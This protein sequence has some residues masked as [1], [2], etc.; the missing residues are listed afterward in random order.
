MPIREQQTTNKQHAIP[1]SIMSVEFKIIGDLTLKQFFY[2]LAFGGGAYACFMTIQPFVFKWILVLFLTGAGLCFAFLPLGDR[3]LDVW[4]VNFIKAMLAPNQYVYR[5]QEE[6]PNVFL[7]QNLDVLRSELITLSPT[8]SRRK[9]EAYLEQQS[10]PIDKLDI[11]ERS[12]VLMVKSAYGSD[13]GYGSAPTTTVITTEE[14]LEAQPAPPAEVVETPAAQPVAQPVA[15]ADLTKLELPSGKPAPQIQQPSLATPEPAPQVERIVKSQRH[16][17]KEKTEPQDNYYSPTITPDMHAGRRFINLTPN[18]GGGGEIILPI[19]GERVLKSADTQRLENDEA[20]KAKQLDLLINQIK[21]S[22]SAQER[23]AEAQKFSEQEKSQIEQLRQQTEAEK[24]AAR[25]KE[26]QEEEIKQA[27]VAV[28]TVNNRPQINSEQENTQAYIKIQQQSIPLKPAQEESP[29][30][31]N[32]I[33]GIVT[34]AQHEPRMPIPGVVAV[35]RNQRNEVVR[36]V[37]T[38]AQGRF[39]ISTPLINGRYIVE[40]DKER[41]SGLNFEPVEVEAKGEVLPTMEVVGKP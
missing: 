2:L 17:Q 28:N 23:L 30:A 39:S 36:A 12:Y 13:Y 11:D 18:A 38:N 24:E 40:V 6:I 27:K 5:K 31:P 1:Q 37:K 20:Q 34:S 15:Q 8:T 35:I 22:E 4:I 41:R 10:T 16:V 14:Q 25:R 29:T 21:S 7:Y 33:W 3:G 9:I 32:I 26:A 19:R